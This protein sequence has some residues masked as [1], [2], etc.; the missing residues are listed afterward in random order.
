MHTQAPLLPSPPP[1]QKPNKSQSFLSKKCVHAAYSE[2]TTAHVMFI[3]SPV[4]SFELSRHKK[5]GFF[6][7]VA[8]NKCIQKPTVKLYL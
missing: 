5:G 2:M 1:H 4:A 7:I 8:I 6:F 3:L